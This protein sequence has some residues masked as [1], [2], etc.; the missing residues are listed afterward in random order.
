MLKSFLKQIFLPLAII[1]MC[2]IL[3]YS[4]YND[5]KNE[6]INQ[7]NIE[8]LTHAKQAANGIQLFFGKYEALLS[9]LVNKNSIIGLGEDGKALIDIFYNSHSPQIRAITRIDET[10]KIIYTVP[11]NS[12]FVGCDI[13]EQEHIQRLLKTHQR[14]V[15]DVFET[16]QGYRSIAYYLPVFK[17]GLFK[18]GLAI[19]IPFDSLAKNYLQNIKVRKS[20]FAWT[21]SQKGIVIYNPIPGYNNQNAF[22]LFADSPA[23]ISILKKSVNGESG[24]GL[25]TS[26][27][28]ETQPPSSK[29][30]C[31]VYYPV[32]IADRFWSIIVVTPEAEA[33]STMQVFMNK[34]IIIVFLLVIGSLFYLYHTIKVRSILNEQRNRKK[35]EEALR[36]SEQKFK[37]LFQTAGDA[38][39]LIELN[40][41]II[42]ANNYASEKF[43]YTRDEFLHLTILE[44]NLPNNSDEISGRLN[45]LKENRELYFETTYNSKTNEHIPVGVNVRLIDYEERKVALSIVRD[46]SL[47][48]KEEDEL[49]RAKE[50]AEKASKLKSEFLAQMSHEIRTP[51]N[52]V[53][54]FTQILKDELNEHMTEEML[55]SFKGIDTAGKRII[56]TVEL[57][58]NMSELQTGIYEFIPNEFDLAADVLENVFDEY[59]LAARK[60]GLEFRLLKN[61]N[62]S[63][64][65]ADQFSTSQIFVN[66]IDNAI[67]YTSTGGIEVTINRNSKNEVA[68]TVSDTGIGISKDFLPKLFD[69][70]TQEEQ[71]YTRKYEGIGLG[72]ALVQKYCEINNVAIQVKTEKNK[73]TKFTLCFLNQL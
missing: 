57:I 12:K 67:K 34:W 37:T 41:K 14:I 3:L 6:T 56:R 24:S 61:T 11:N 35:A 10:G 47:K 66:L 59:E 1:G 28:T 4:A 27:D 50:E 29:N 20:G 19:L 63:I 53:V 23:L 48:K 64:V 15:S 69:P 22:N 60:K 72:M 18:G 38:I 8:Q 7:L 73:G 32:K 52:V 42:E 44:L 31:A 46:I 9:Y 58:L 25:Y 49:I 51:L 5:V 62:N 45:L 33:L 36:Q 43:G 26:T 21:I 2:I 39:F 55:T 16:V 30:I 68:V 71:G 13:S 70:F 40:G 17:E 54:G 65:S